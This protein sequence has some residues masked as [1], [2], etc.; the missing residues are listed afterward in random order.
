[1]KK[2][3]KL[4]SSYS[5]LYNDK[6]DNLCRRIGKVSQTRQNSKTEEIKSDWEKR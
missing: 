3:N 6:L 2:K 5:K 1:M 4:G